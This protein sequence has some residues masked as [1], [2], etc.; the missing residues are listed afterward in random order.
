MAKLFLNLGEPSL[1]NTYY[2]VYFFNSFGSSP[3]RPSQ[4]CRPPWFGR[5]HPRPAGPLGVEGDLGSSGENIARNMMNDNIRNFFQHGRLT[6]CVKLCY[7]RVTGLIDR[8]WH[9]KLFH[10]ARI[11]QRPPQ[12]FGLLCF[13]QMMRGCLPTASYTTSLS[14]T[15]L[16]LRTPRCCQ[17]MLCSLDLSGALQERSEQQKE[18][19]LPFSPA[20]GHS[21]NMRVENM[22]LGDQFYKILATLHALLETCIPW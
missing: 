12:T 19:K 21:Q 17:F 1:F 6:N 18:G 5:S 22:K 2:R 14:Y 4:P 15:I 13:R 9:R 16:R 8:G 10:R 7:F 11:L 3:C 20:V